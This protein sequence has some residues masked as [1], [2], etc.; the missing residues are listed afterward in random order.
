M[1]RGVAAGGARVVLCKTLIILRGQFA[2]R[3]WLDGPPPPPPPRDCCRRRFRTKF[4]FLS[5][6]I[7]IAIIIVFV[8]VP[9][10]RKN[11]T[12]YPST[13]RSTDVK[14]AI[15]VDC[16]PDIFSNSAV[17]HDESD[18]FSPFTRRIS[19]QEIRNTSR[20]ALAFLSPPTG[21]ISSN[22]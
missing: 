11:I 22:L 13:H 10:K 2:P 8:L 17:N 18:I 14:Q 5:Y 12:Y 4:C 9:L 20:T 6:I 7:M 16:G 21:F 15:S 1:R 3:L 19:F